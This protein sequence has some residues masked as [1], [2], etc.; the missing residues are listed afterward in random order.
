MM[1]CSISLPS[2]PQIP[3]VP[4]PAPQVGPRPPLLLP[5][6]LS[7]AALPAAAATAS[8]PACCCLQLPQ[9]RTE[10]HSGAPA[11]VAAVLPGC[12]GGV[13][14][15]SSGGGSVLLLMRLALTTGGGG[16]L[17]QCKPLQVREFPIYLRP[18]LV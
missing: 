2:L 7:A 13:G 16:G 3:L 11:L 15:G 5:A 1:P 8:A 14:S 12:G 17:G 4:Q 9:I 10:P 18:A 6:A